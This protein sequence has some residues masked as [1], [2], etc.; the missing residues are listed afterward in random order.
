MA[1]L[2]SRT[3][4]LYAESRPLLSLVSGG[5]GVELRLVWLGGSRILDRIEAVGYDVF[6][7]RPTL[8]KPEV[9]RLVA[10]ALRG[11]GALA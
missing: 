2:V 11:P 3:R 7:R 9:L 6:R 4:A 5:L 8:S 1:E 10:R